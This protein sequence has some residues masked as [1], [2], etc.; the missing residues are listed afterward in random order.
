MSASL[1]VGIV[2]A[3]RGSSFIR[4]FRTIRQTEVVAL[5]DVNETTLNRIGDAHEIDRRFTSYD[6]LLDWGVDIVVIA[7]PMRFH[8]PQSIAALNAGVHVLSEVT[9]A[10]TIGECHQLRDAALASGAHYM[11]AE[12]YCYMKANV[13]VRSLAH[14]GMFGELY[15]AEGEYV[16]DVKFLHHDA[17][18]NP[19]WRYVDQVGKNGCTYGTHSLGPVLQWLQERVVTVSCVGSGIHTDPEHAIDDTVLMNC[20]TESGALV[21]IR[22][23]MMS[24]RPHGMNYY[25]LQGT[26]GCYEAPRGFGDSHKIWLADRCDKVEW[27]SLWDFEEEFMPDMWRNPPEEALQAGHGGGDYFEVRDFVDAIVKDEP[28]PISIWDA[29]DFTLPGLVSEDSIAYGGVPLPVP[30]LRRGS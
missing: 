30:D 16:H 5:C 9:A 4:A 11:M 10:M 8:A 25:A 13:L 26:K 27:R 2:G 15:F 22:L 19:T 28:P 23:D 29:L 24:N 1:R 3:P 12:N 18:G 6:D 20:K 17:Q 21:K 7:T 14:E